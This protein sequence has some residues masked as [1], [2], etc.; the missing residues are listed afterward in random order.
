MATDGKTTGVSREQQRNLVDRRLIEYVLPLPKGVR[1]LSPECAFVRFADTGIT[2]DFGSFCYLEREEKKRRAKG[3]ATKVV[4]ASLSPLRRKLI[5]RFIQELSEALDQGGSPGTQYLHAQNFFYFLTWADSSHKYDVLSSASSAKQAL[6][7]FSEHLSEKIRTQALAR[8]TAAIYQRLAIRWT[9]LLLGNPGIADGLALLRREEGDNGTPPRSEEA[10]GR[11]LAID[12][13]LFEGISRLVLE[14]SPFPYALQLPNFLQEPGNRVWLFPA[15]GFFRTLVEREN[16]IASG[17][18]AY[19]FANGRLRTYEECRPFHKSKK[20]ARDAVSV[21]ASRLRVVNQNAR[22][23]QRVELAKIALISFI[24]M[25]L[26]NTG[27]DWE[28]VRTLKWFSQYEVERVSQDF[29]SIK[30][31]AGGA[32]VTFTISSRFLP[33]FRQFLALRNWVLDG[34]EWNLLF[35]CPVEIR[36]NGDFSIRKLPDSSPELLYTLRRLLPS[37]SH[38]GSRE[39]R[40]TKTNWHVDNYGVVV[41]AAVAQNTPETVSNKYSAGTDTQTIKETGSFLGELSAQFVTRAKSDAGVTT[42]V[43]GCNN[44]K[45]PKP[46]ALRTPVVP[47]CRQS[48]G[49]LFCK[50]HVLVADETD[51]R[52]LFS[53]RYCILY[54]RSLSS[55]RRAWKETFG[56]VLVRIKWLLSRISCKSARHEALVKR[57]R[58]EVSVNGALDPYWEKKLMMLESIMR[59]V[60]W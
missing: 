6:V 42:S 16:I 5:H 13:H 51:V 46:V 25:F 3:C 14:G 37:I 21:A 11:Q 7:N 49:C 44:F 36:E 10:I 22:C 55:T 28:Q 54:T 19:D 29:S 2:R 35:F 9:A 8:K 31:R 48:E 56:P 12:K 32:E 18:S 53:L 50:E 15:L 60:T 33:R 23:R 40:A 17:S 24:D 45:K 30:A 20:S 26:A 1:I 47:D 52:K 39:W 34:K 59:G 27:M 4:M 38:I 41:A 58:K 57:V 43:G